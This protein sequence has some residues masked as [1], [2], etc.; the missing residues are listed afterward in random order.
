MFSGGE[1]LINPLDEVRALLQQVRTLFDGKRIVTT[2][3]TYHQKI[4]TLF[5]EHLVDGIHI[6][7]KL[8]YHV[9][10][11]KEDGQIYKDIMGSTPSKKV[12]E[13]LNAS[14]AAVTGRYSALDN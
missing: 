3:G 4:R 11:V 9:V 7:M 10:D 8:P 14:V 12:V 2:S 1:F 6:D 13:Q 5:G